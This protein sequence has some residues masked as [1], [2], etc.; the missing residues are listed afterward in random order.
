M[1]KKQLEK[2]EE[3]LPAE[4]PSIEEQVANIPV[5]K[6]RLENI[7]KLN[8]N[9]KCHCGSGMKYKF[10]CLEKDVTTNN[11]YRVKEIG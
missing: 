3:A 5:K 4:V 8:R 10:C 7:H 6:Y 9:D 11:R 1:N 2:L